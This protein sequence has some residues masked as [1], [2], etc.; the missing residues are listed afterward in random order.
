MEKKSEKDDVFCKY[1]VSQQ[2]IVICFPNS[3]IDY[4][5]NI[6]E[7]MIFFLSSMQQFNF[8]LSMSVSQILCNE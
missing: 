2:I 3:S 5:T 6:N 1:G 8:N 7:Q 4:E